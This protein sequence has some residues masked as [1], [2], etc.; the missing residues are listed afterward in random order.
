MS[1]HLS[2]WEWAIIGIVIAVLLFGGTD[3]ATDTSGRQFE[4][5][6][7][8]R[9][10]TAR[11]VRSFKDGTSLLLITIVSIG[12]AHSDD[13]AYERTAFI[14]Y[15]CW[16]WLWI[17]AAVI[18]PVVLELLPIPE[19]WAPFAQWA[20]NIGVLGTAIGSA[21]VYGEELGHFSQWG[22]C[23]F[24]IVVESVQVLLQWRPAAQVPV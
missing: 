4:I 13:E 17:A 16:A 3:Y 21:V 11:G 10:G 23:V 19:A 24:A 20:F 5:G 12:I 15:Q 2:S 6:G 7:M 14:A 22:V 18:D 9:R 8:A 1:S